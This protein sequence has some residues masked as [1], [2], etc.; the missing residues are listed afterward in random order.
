MV[1]NH[2]SRRLFLKA[3]SLSGLAL[4]HPSF[5]FS[6]TASPFAGKF[7]LTVQARGAWDV[8]YFCDPKENQRGSDVITN[9]SRSDQTA[10]TGNLKYAPVAKN[11]SFF[12]RHYS[13]ILII[14]GVDAQTN[15]HSI[16][17]TA[18]WSGRTADG[19]PSITALYAAVNAPELP[20]TYLSFGGFSKTA[21]LLRPTMLPHSASDLRFYLRPNTDHGGNS[22]IDPEVWSL[23]R[24]L[25]ADGARSMLEDE[26][27]LAR[28]RQNRAA[29]LQSVSS[30]E[31][32]A[33][34][35]ATL[36]TQ[37]E[38]QEISRGNRLTSQVNFALLA[39]RAGVSCT[40]DLQQGGFDSHND[41]DTQQIQLLGELTDALD[42]L[43]DF[44]EALG[45]ADRLLVI[46]GSDFSRTP[47]YNSGNGKDHWPIGS[48]M[49]MEKG[50]RYTN[51][52]IGSTDEAQNAMGIDLATLNP[53]NM[54][55]TKLLTAH[56]QKAL[57]NYLGLDTAAV[58]Q[59][60]PLI[61]TESINFFS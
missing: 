60:F 30:N 7:V 1:K 54:G 8:T 23:I 24:K 45:I 56:V 50:K 57:R 18:N 61:N 51:R 47:Y 58:T 48:F 40:A 22:I 17:E 35:A 2:S 25:N 42:Y 55:G 53:M 10:S 52:V 44:A 32:L 26:K 20:M 3:L 49:I 33:E 13:K 9:W 46:V 16:G 14:N 38:E 12:E 59:G 5:V 41:N 43:W 37:K 19:Y 28:S 11:Q 34:F 4:A 21:N 6:A 15:S 29:Y 27:V 39:F 36:P 31:A